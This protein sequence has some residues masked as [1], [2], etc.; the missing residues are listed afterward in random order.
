MKNFTKEIKKKK[1]PWRHI[2]TRCLSRPCQEAYHHPS[3]ERNQAKWVNHL[4][5]V[6]TQHSRHSIL[7][8]K[9]QFEALIH[10]IFVLGYPARF[11]KKMAQLKHFQETA[12]YFT[13][14]RVRGENNSVKHRENFFT[15]TILILIPAEN[16]P[17]ER[18]LT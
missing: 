6:Q 14:S 13:K 16:I 3:T 7:P 10:R 5:W 2:S 17:M 1:T 12:I 15:Q 8:I 11:R 4:T 18:F 9:G